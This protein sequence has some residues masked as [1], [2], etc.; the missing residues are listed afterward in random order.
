MAGSSVLGGWEQVWR[1]RWHEGE[2][3]GGG[4]E[5]SERDSETGTEKQERQRLRQRDSDGR[6]LAKWPM[7]GPIR[8]SE[9]MK[10]MR[11]LQRGG[12]S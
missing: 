7:P 2:R 6:R 1:Q 9:T 12:S 11:P 5:A 3:G 8:L 4:G 10:H